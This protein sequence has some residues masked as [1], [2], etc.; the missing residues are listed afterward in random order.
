MKVRKFLSE[1]NWT[2]RAEAVD[3][4]GR[5]CEARS[6]KAIKFCLSGALSRCY[7]HNPKRLIE[8]VQSINT[9]IRTFYN[10]DSIISWNDDEKRE[11][12]DIEEIISILDI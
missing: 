5:P 6:N 1:L 3:D 7:R 12:A 4:N 9:F 10:Y 8:S 11:W 2:K